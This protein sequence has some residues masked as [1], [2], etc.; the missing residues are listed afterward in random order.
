MKSRYPLRVFQFSTENFCGE[1]KMKKEFIA[2][3]FDDE[4][5]LNVP[6]YVVGEWAAHWAHDLD[7]RSPQTT[8]VTHIPTGFAL[9]ERILTMKRAKE[10]AK[11]LDQ[12][13]A[14]QPLQ[15]VAQDGG[16]HVT[17]PHSIQEVMM[18]IRRDTR[19]G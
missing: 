2:L 4:T 18:V 6:A 9:I 17:E 3:Q 13:L 1:L 16:Y 10:A 7:G 11:K 8:V 19:W 5:V 12:L 15:Y 14:G